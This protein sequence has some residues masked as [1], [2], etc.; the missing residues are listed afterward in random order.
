MSDSTLKGW[1]R[2]LAERR[3]SGLCPGCGVKPDDEKYKW[4]TACR[5]KRSLKAKIADER[6]KKAEAESNFRTRLEI[7][8]KCE[9][10]RILDGILYCPSAYGTCIANDIIAS[11]DS[12]DEQE[13]END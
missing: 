12:S 2:T 3:A 4:C 13:K 6:N 5:A 11:Y 9:W 7:C 10:A 8:K 1:R